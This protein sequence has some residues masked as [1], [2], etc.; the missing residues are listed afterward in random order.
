MGIKKAE[1]RKRE[2]KLVWTLWYMDKKDHPH[3][4]GCF[5]TS[6][7]ANEYQRECLRPSTRYRVYGIPAS[8][9]SML[10]W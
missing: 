3:Y 10:I 1:M 8:R 5:F 4:K 7:E 2:R 9:I 6:G